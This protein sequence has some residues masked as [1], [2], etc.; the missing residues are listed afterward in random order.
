[1]ELS[2]AYGHSSTNFGRR[3]SA[4]A[5]PRA[6]REAAAAILRA[7]TSE[8]YAEGRAAFAEK[9]EPRFRGR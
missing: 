5:S 9:R 8:D 3:W 2:N 7:L 6:P 4:W 1:M